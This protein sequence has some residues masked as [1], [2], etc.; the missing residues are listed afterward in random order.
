MKIFIMPPKKS[1]MTGAVLTPLDT[2]QGEVAW[3]QKRKAVST[4]PQDD[5][6]DQK[7]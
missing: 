1:T 3:N 6:L 4:T 7:I 2:N 5:V